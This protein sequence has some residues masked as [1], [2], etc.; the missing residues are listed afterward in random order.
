METT[1]TAEDL[2]LKI[3][4]I[5]SKGNKYICKIQVINHLIYISIYLENILKFSGCISLPKIQNQIVA[6]LYYNIN[7]IFEEIN[8]LDSN[9]F[10]LIKENNENKLQIKFI[11]LRRKQYL[12]ISLDE[13]KNM[14]LI[15]NDLV[16]Q[17][18]ELREIIKM[19]DEKINELEEQLNEYKKQKANLDF[20]KNIKKED[21]YNDFNIK[22]RD[23]IHKLKYHSNN[24][25]CLTK[26]KDGRIASGS[27]VNSI[28]IYNK[29]TFKQLKNII[30]L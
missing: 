22:L 20:E 19:K 3:I 13:N 26:L 5:E 21:L 14:N 8:L 12:Y 23:P 29:E 6:F 15:Y 17:I 2:S 30:V 9:N 4:E 25:Y 24:V 10:S 11:I 27:G 28:I 16:K 18:S 7:E 1:K